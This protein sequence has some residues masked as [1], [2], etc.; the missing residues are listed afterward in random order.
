[1]Y[2]WKFLTRFLLLS[3]CRVS[4]F[5]MEKENFNLKLKRRLDKAKLANFVVLHASE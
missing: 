1:M 5:P 4:C 3:V 2:T